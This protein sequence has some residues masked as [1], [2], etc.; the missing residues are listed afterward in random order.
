[1]K[2]TTL[3]DDLTIAYE[4]TGSGATALVFAHGAFANRSHYAAQI[5]HLSKHHRVVALDIRGHGESDTPSR[6]FGI[7]EAAA[8]VIAVCD[9]AGVERAVIVGHSWAV[10]LQVG[11][12]RRQ[13]VAGVV[14]LDGAVLLPE[15]MRTQL[16]QELVPVLEGPGWASAMQGFLVGRGFPYPAPALQARV[17]EE[18]GH[19][20]AQLAAQMM[21]D[22]MST[23]W[24]QQLLSVACPLLY[25]HSGMPMDVQRLRQLRPDALV[26]VVAGGGHYI[27]LEVPDQVNAMIDRFL[28]L[29]GQSLRRTEIT[30][31]PQLGQTANTQPAAAP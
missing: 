3:S 24:S 7:R 31:S 29:S 26:G 22:V 11:Q 6:P 21:R 27:S 16:L 20:S 17:S 9:A 25:I 8:D 18:I 4:D 23:D 5:E 19:G 15:T 10:P 1:M 14:L 13:L 12:Q 28:E 30:D 2:R